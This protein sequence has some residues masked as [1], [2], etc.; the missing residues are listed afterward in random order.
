M[1]GL[2]AAVAAFTVTMNVTVYAPGASPINGGMLAA[3]GAVLQDGHAACGRIYPFGTEFEV[4]GRVAEEL[5]KRS[6]PTVVTC[7]DRGGMVGSA[8][9]DIALLNGTAR[10]RLDRA[11]DFGRRW[12]TVLVRLPEPPA[13]KTPAKRSRTTAGRM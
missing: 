9:L 2:L 8:N 11:Y 4:T 3:N 12:A 10:D 13:S 5:Q 6:I 7:V 1:D